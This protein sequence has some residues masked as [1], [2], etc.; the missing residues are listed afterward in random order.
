MAHGISAPTPQITG[1]NDKI[2]LE[3]GT[4]RCDS[5]NPKIEAKA[6]GH[7]HPISGSPYADTI[8]V[9]PISDH[10]VE[11]VNKKKG[12][13]TGRNKMTVSAERED[14]NQRMGEHFRQRA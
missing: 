7:D 6:D 4:Y 9:R 12:K 2:S 3:N 11:I 10:E 8:N 13:V 14:F 5:C 1:N